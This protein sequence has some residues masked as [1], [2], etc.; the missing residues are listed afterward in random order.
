MK[1]DLKNLTAEFLPVTQLHSLNGWDE[2]DASTRKSVETETKNLSEAIVTWGKSRLAIG[3]HLTKIQEKLE[4]QRMFGKFLDA[5]NLKRSTAYNYITGY[6]NAS[7]VLSDNILQ[8][9]SS[10][11]INMIGIRETQPLGVYTDAVK[12][13]PPPTSSNMADINDWLK[14]VESVR[15]K[16]RPAEI[17]DTEL[18]MKECYRYVA[19]RL[20]KVPSKGRSRRAWLDRLVGMIL[21]EVGISNGANFTPEGI[22]EEFRA[23]P[24]RPRLAA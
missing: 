7:S 24:G 1:T 14:R 15:K 13:I 6:K 10:R 4:P 12:K 23:V 21:T 11:G 2:L 9:V 18:M 20:G 5:F 17:V 3:E 16:S 22:P 19:T 8:V